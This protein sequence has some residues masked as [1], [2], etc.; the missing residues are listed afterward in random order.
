M[1]NTGRGAG[2]RA[3]D[4]EARVRRGRGR[5]QGV[6]WHYERELREKEGEIEEEGEK[7]RRGEE[8]KEE[9]CG[10]AG[11]HGRGPQFGR[12]TRR[13]PLHEDEQGDQI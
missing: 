8:E 2:R 9:K 6:R 10:E 3:R 1:R 13:P 5:R 4:Q 11:R 12:R 7:G